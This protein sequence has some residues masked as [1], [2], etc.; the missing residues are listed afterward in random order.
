[1]MIHHIDIQLFAARR[2]L[3]KESGVAN[4]DKYME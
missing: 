4:V 2:S 1:M 3:E